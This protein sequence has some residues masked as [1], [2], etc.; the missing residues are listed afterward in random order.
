MPAQITEIDYR[1]SIVFEESIVDGEVQWS[2]MV[3]CMIAD[4]NIKPVENMDSSEI[5]FSKLKIDDQ[6]LFL[7]KED[8]WKPAKVLFINRMFHVLYHYRD[9]INTDEIWEYDLSTHKTND[10]LR[11]K[12]HPSDNIIIEYDFISYILLYLYIHAYI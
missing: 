2:S 6:C 9:N 11:E 8:E 3:D 7:A 4:N 1:V 12:V 10:Y 5:W